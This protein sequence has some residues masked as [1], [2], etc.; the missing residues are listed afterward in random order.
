M[1]FGKQVPSVLDGHAVET[2]CTNPA[3]LSGGSGTLISMYRTSLPTQQVAGNVNEGIFA[4]PPPAS[5]TPWIE[6]NG[7]YSASCVMS[8]G[9]NVLKVVANSGAPALSS[10][11]YP[12]ATWGLHVDDPNLALGN[13]VALVSSEAIAYA[14]R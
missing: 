9:A 10:Y 14:R 12:D 5:S 8:N 1:I 2:V 6:Y 7:L 11:P 4:S 13:L 3:N